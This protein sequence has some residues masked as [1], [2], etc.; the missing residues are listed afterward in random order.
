MMRRNASQILIVSSLIGG[1]MFY[2]FHRLAKLFSTLSGDV[3]TKINAAII[4]LPQDL[5]QRPID[6][7]FTQQSLMIG[8]IA[9]CSCVVV[10]IYIAAGKKNYRPGEEYGS[11]RW[12]TPKDSGPFKDKLQDKNIILTQTEVLSMAERM[13]KAEHDRNKNVMV[14][15]G[16]GSG[17]TRGYV[18]PNL[19]QLYSSYVI[20]ES[21]GLLPHETGNLFVQEESEGYRIK[22][23]DLVNRENCDFFNPFAYIKKEDNILMVVDNFLK[24]TD[25]RIKK[26][27]DPFW[28]KAEKALYCAI[29]GYLLEVGSVSEQT[30]EMVSR[31]IREG[32]TEG[33]DDQLV[34]PLDVLFKELEKEQEHHFAV[35]QYQIF[36]LA[37]VKTARSIL[38]CAGVRLAPFDIPSVAHLT[39][40]DTLELEKIGDEKTVLFICLP[41]TFEAFNFLAAILYQLLFEVLLNKADNEYHGRLPIPVRCILDEF[42]NIGQI[43]NFDRVISVV[44]SRGISIDVIIQAMSQLKNLYRDTWETIMGSCDTLLYLGGMEKSTHKYIS[45]LCEK[46]TIDVLDTSQ[47]YGGQGSYSKQFKKQ[48][49]DLITPG[50]V[51]TLKNTECILKIRG[52]PP[53]KSKKYN[54]TKHKRYKHLS[55]SDQK[56]WYEYNVALRPMEEFLKNVSAV[57]TFDFSKLQDLAGNQGG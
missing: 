32:R 30:F 11:A 33:D 43:P 19:A 8:G 3:F 35:K 10:G 9:L 15:G 17:K 4:L 1:F 44:R 34:S 22:I 5:Q 6:L 46:E 52:V 47:S 27:G 54:L 39:S 12:G 37:A 20:T 18:K 40:K 56:N 14:I 24:N 16:A 2:L 48:G 57:E 7:A 49:R 51:A 53:F 21:K 26:S 36:K 31:L 23:F 42:G 25:G 28:E 50:E 45:E 41:D 29:F 38:I 55:D 13:P